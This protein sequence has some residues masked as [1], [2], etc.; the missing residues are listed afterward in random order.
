MSKSMTNGKFMLYAIDY[1]DKDYV[2]SCASFDVNDNNVKVTC[3]VNDK[4][5]KEMTIERENA[6]AMWKSLVED[7]YRQQDGTLN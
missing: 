2:L 1:E 6:R 3:Y 5:L 4:I 7:G